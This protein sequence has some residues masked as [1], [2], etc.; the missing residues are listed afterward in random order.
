MGFLCV[1]G[2]SSNSA[3]LV[4]GMLLLGSTLV[5]ALVRGMLL[6]VRLQNDTTDRTPPGV[7][8]GSS[9][10]EEVLAERPGDLVVSETAGRRSRLKLK[11]ASEASEA[12][13]MAMGLCVLL[14]L[15]AGVL[16]E[17]LSVSVC[18]CLQV[19]CDGVLLGLCGCCVLLGLCGCCVLEVSP[20][21]TA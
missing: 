3:P 21:I 15:C 6:K 12:P 13:S 10:L 20:P 19:C 14:G 2:D 8:S 17:A 4:R 11:M 18:L 16:L 9:E 1:S 5:T 7:G